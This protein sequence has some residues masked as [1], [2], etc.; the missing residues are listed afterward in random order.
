MERNLRSSSRIPLIG[1]EESQILGSKLPTIKQVL[2]VFFYYY[3]STGNN[4]RGSA[5]SATR[6]AIVFWEKA[7]ISIRKEQ[8]CI[9]KLEKLFGEW[10]LITKNSSRES[11]AQRKKEAEFEA[12]ICKLFDIA[13]SDAMTMLP[14]DGQL[15]LTNQRSDNREGGLAGVEKKLMQREAAVEN[16]LM[17]KEQ[18]KADRIDVENVRKRRYLERQQPHSCKIF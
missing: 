13:H 5:T 1:F 18:R 4:I 9:E 3:N 14:E 12:K 10:R 2:Q 17:Q 16:K 11:E 7:K 15:F 6:Q 8:H